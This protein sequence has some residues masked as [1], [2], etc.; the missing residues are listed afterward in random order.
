MHLLPL[1]TFA[2][3][4]CLVDGTYG[5]SQIQPQANSK[6]NS[7]DIDLVSDLAAGITGGS[8]RAQSQAGSASSTPQTLT[9]SS[10]RPGA[11]GRPVF[12]FS[13]G[14]SAGDVNGEFASRSSSSRSGSNLRNG[15]CISKR[16][17]LVG[18]GS[19]DIGG[20]S[21]SSSTGSKLSSER[22]QQRSNQKGKSCLRGRKPKAARA[23]RHSISL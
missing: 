18:K 8:N 6:R 4:I 21:G 14:V 23:R 7:L 5:E 10:S 3:V 9:A 20:V 11:E 12:D 13:F 2:L 16:D 15:L 1:I 22:D 17:S 19:S